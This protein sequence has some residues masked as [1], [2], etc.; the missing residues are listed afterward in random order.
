MANVTTFKCR[1]NTNVFK[2]AK[3]K[4]IRIEL[5]REARDILLR[6]TDDGGGFVPAARNRQSDRSSLGLVNM[7]ERA[8]FIRGSLTVRST[9]GEGTVI[10]VRAPMGPVRN[11][12]KT[13]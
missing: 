6:V 3:A 5:L 1:G 9:P 7:R 11:K 4:V 13:P 8:G 2:H 10:E 12:A